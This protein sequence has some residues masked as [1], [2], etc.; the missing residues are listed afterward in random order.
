MYPHGALEMVV[1]LVVRDIWSRSRLPDHVLEQIWNL[2]DGQK[3]GLLTKA[4]F[5]VGLWLI[6][7]QLKGHKLPG[8]VPDSVW[9]SVARTPGISLDDFRP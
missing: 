9:A 2:V 1:S 5:V 7:Q 3:I 4:E 6:D 8:A